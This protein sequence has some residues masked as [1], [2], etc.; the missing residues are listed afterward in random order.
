MGSSGLAFG[1]SGQSAWGIGSHQNLSQF[2]EQL[3]IDIQNGKA[4]ARVPRRFLPTLHGGDGGWFDV[5]E[6]AIGDSDIKGKVAINIANHPNLRID[7][8]SGSVALD[9]KVGAFS[10]QCEKFAPDQKAF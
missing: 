7:R 3:D 6:L 8:R 9:G 4:R 5:I 1:S 2:G 10:G